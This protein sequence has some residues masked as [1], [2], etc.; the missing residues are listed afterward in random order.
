LLISKTL[1][2]RQQNK[3]IDE[4]ITTDRNALNFVFKNPTADPTVFSLQY[5]QDC[6]NDFT[7]KVLGEGA[8]GR[9]YFGCDKVLGIQMAVKR[10]PIPLLDQEIL[11]QVT[12]S[13]KREISV[14]LE[15]FYQIVNFFAAVTDTN[16]LII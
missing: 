11:D 5:L 13:F 9:V 12:L 15:K 7:S 8:F 2:S 10:I 14:S 3:A 16:V 1:L 6:T 4:E